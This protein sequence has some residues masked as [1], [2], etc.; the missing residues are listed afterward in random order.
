M[1]SEQEVIKHLNGRNQTHSRKRTLPWNDQR[2]QS[3][4]SEDEEISVEPIDVNII[5]EQIKKLLF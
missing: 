5:V 3:N 2:P 4:N 1:S